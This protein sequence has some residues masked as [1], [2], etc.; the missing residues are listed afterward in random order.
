MVQAGEVAQVD[1]VDPGTADVGGHQ[2]DQ[3]RLL[4]PAGGLQ[5]HQRGAEFEQPFD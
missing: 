3:Q 2:L 5:H 1:R 4:V